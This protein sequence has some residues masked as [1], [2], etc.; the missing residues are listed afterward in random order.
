MQR[1]RD[2]YQAK[3][4]GI[5]GGLSGRVLVLKLNN[6]DVALDPPYAQNPAMA[7][8]THMTMDSR[9]KVLATWP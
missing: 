5:G 2:A 1:V 9:F 3:V 7:A 4:A 8:F 6:V